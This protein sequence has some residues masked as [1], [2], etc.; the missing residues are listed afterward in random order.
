MQG[1]SPQEENPHRDIPQLW[2]QNK[3]IQQ[4]NG[5][6]AKQKVRRIKSFN[7]RINKRI[8]TKAKRVDLPKDQEIDLP[9]DQ[10]KGKEINFPGGEHNKA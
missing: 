5:P 1:G 7:K 9:K 4:K 2:N 3:V 6:R 8:K 10:E